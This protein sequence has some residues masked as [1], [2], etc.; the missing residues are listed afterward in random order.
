MA[1]L[2]FKTGGSSGVGDVGGWGRSK[3]VLQNKIGLPA[4]YL[5]FF[6]E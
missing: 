6:F 2:G 5:N 1:K 4:N 3:N